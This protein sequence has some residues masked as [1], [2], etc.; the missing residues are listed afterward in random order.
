M[1]DKAPDPVRRRIELTQS[2]LTSVAILV[3]G[4]YAL[5]QAWIH[6]DTWQIATLDQKVDSRRI[7]SQYVWLTISTHI[8]NDG[9]V[10]VRLPKAK[11]II[12]RV[13]P[14]SEKV[15]ASIRDRS[16]NFTGGGRIADWPVLCRYERDIGFALEPGESD[17]LTVE[18]F[19]P[20][21]LK[22]VKIFTFLGDSDDP[23]NGWG[24][25]TVYDIPKEGSNEAIAQPV[26]DSDSARLLCPH[27]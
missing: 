17:I 25:A 9:K 8:R 3:G 22:T 20:A 24:R 19:V 10:L 27:S 14:A 26:G 15:V 5:Y 2:V 18:A 6:R 16:L 13:L 1:G 23:G 21:Y 11:V 4:A 12:Y 7:D